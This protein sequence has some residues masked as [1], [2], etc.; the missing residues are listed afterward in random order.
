MRVSV[1]SRAENPELAYEYIKALFA[2]GPLLEG[3]LRDQGNLPWMLNPARTDYYA[4]V[5]DEGESAYTC[6]GSIDCFDI[7]QVG[8]DAAKYFISEPPYG[9]WFPEVRDIVKG[10]FDLVFNGEMTLDEAIEAINEEADAVMQVY[11][12]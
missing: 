9:A 4:T 10:N 6:Y 1:S 2:D 11:L 3:F 5:V 8:R 12:P 7:T